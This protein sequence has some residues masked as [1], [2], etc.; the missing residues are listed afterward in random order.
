[1]RDKTNYNL[2]SPEA[3]YSDYQGA[4][5]RVNYLYNIMMPGNASTYVWF[6][7]GGSDR[8]S[9]ATEEYG[10]ID[11]YWINEV[12]V[13]INK[14]D[15]A[16]DYFYF[17]MKATTPYGR[18]RESNEIIESVKASSFTEVE[19]AN[20]LGQAYFF[21]AWQ[22]FEMVKYLGGIPIVDHVQDPIV[23]DGSKESIVVPRSTTKEC[24]EF[25]CNDLQTAADYLPVAWQE[26]A[27]DYGRITKGA[28]LA[29]KGRV[30]LWFASPLFNRQDKAVRWTEAYEA[31]K[32]VK[33]LLA[34]SMDPGINASEWARMFAP[35][36]IVHKEG[37]M[38]ALRS[39]NEDNS[40]TNSWENSIRPKNIFGG[41]GIDVTAQMIDL[42]P[43]ADGKTPKGLGYTKLDSSEYNPNLFFL[44]RD[45]RFY[46]TFAFP[47][48]RWTANS[49]FSAA[50]RSDTLGVFLYPYQGKEYQLWSYAWYKNADS[51]DS[52]NNTGDSWVADGIGNTRRTVYLRKRSDDYDIAKTSMYEFDESTSVRYSRS[53][54][55]YYELRYGEVLLNFA[56]AA[57]GAGKGDEAL[58]ALRELRRRV[59]YSGD[60][61]LS[62]SLAG[63]RAAL[64]SAILYERQIE[65][66]YEGK[67]F[68]DMRRWML[69][70]GGANQF[71]VEGAPDNWMP[72][73]WGG[74]TCEY[75]GVPE[76]NG[77]RRQ[78]IYV[79]SRETS[80]NQK[81]NGMVDGVPTVFDP[82]QLAAE[83]GSETA[84]RP[85]ALNLMEDDVTT[86]SNGEPIGA[87]MKALVE[88]YGNNLGVKRPNT[89]DGTKT[90]SGQTVPDLDIVID[91]KPQ[92]YFIGLKYNAQSGNPTLLQTIG[93]S[94]RQGRSERFDP[95]A[96]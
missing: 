50:V 87:A 18:I 39:V 26:E 40:R 12:G 30:L 84:V 2:V 68:D 22:Y 23:G 28:A 71:M 78:T 67:R 25:I 61:G 51:R 95:L 35:S 47:G 53:Y 75:L 33:E 16:S 90:E 88:F 91:F 11:S 80:T 5:G 8:Y 72:T 76:L 27:V 37:V 19:K 17:E 83:G 29:V 66:A 55:P 32:E 45:P 96:E 74:N 9:K 64:F 58:E 65:L 62:N 63:D 48:V 73:G 86:D 77:T 4:V 21:R 54:A 10:G 20:L 15:H 24:I 56:E 46:R 57:C 93:W 13:E 85:S 82:V 31:N 6:T 81:N 34:Y 42:F 7:T 49:T 69:W 60:C 38:V 14:T 92:N 94:D 89:V 1:M 41:N 44:N 79:Y 43:M 52:E 70:D 59:G 36:E 3:I